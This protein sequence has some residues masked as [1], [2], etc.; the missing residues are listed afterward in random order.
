MRGGG[1]PVCGLLIQ[2]VSGL[3]GLL[4]GIGRAVDR[5]AGALHLKL[6]GIAVFALSRSAVGHGLT[7]GIG[8]LTRGLRLGGRLLHRLLYGFLHRLRCRLGRRAL[9]DVAA[10]GRAHRLLHRAAAG[11]LFGQLLG[12]AAGSLILLLIQPAGG[13]AGIQLTRFAHGFSSLF[14]EYYFR[15]AFA[16]S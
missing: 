4:L 15:C 7:L 3:P 16:Y 6:Q 2:A 10:L 1:L 12:A 9:T 13:T 14:L 11:V 5:A 8:Q